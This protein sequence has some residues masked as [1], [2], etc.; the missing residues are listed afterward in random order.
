MYDYKEEF[1]AKLGG[2][3]I[4]EVVQVGDNVVIRVDNFTNESFFAYDC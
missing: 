4:A 1:E 2:E 3:W